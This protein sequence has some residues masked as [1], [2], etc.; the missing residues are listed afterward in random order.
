MSHGEGV[1]FQ[2]LHLSSL[3]SILSF[4]S[5][6]KHTWVCWIVWYFVYCSSILIVLSIVLLL[7]LVCLV[8]HCIVLLALLKVVFVILRCL[9][10]VLALGSRC[11]LCLF[12]YWLR[13][14]L[15]LG[16]LI[17]CSLLRLLLFLGPIPDGLNFPFPNVISVSILYAPSFHS[18][19]AIIAYRILV[20]VVRFVWFCLTLLF[21]CYVFFIKW[22]MSM[23]EKF[24][25][26]NS[27][28]LIFFELFVHE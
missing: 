7:L 21:Y 17:L 14:S 9:R 2:N 28:P 13:W 4:A 18:L 20:V 8:L 22:I 23:Y 3:V 10:L 24:M 5:L 12:G 26:Y 19:F 6:S 1:L 11:F 25:S 27:I 15:F 16:S